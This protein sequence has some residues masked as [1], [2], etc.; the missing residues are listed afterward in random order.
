MWTHTHTHQAQIASQTFTQAPSPLRDRM[1]WDLLIG[2]NQ[3]RWYALWEGLRDEDGWLKHSDFVALC[4]GTS[5]WTGRSVSSASSW[6]GFYKNWAYA[7]Y[8]TVC[9]HVRPPSSFFTM[10]VFIIKEYNETWANMKLSPERFLP[11]PCLLPDHWGR[12]R[13]PESPRHSI[14]HGGSE[15]G[16]LLPRTHGTT[17]SNQPQT[18][19]E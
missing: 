8:M 5:L 16:S 11:C 7:C 13:G 4:R 12:H 9:G 15:P 18:K 1:L 10:S 2:I 6:S 17:N 3:K 14:Q 19:V